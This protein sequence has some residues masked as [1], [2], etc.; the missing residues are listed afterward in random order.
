MK[1]GF[2]RCMVFSQAESTPLNSSL[3]GM[4]ALVDY[5]VDYRA[6]GQYQSYETDLLK[7]AFLLSLYDQNQV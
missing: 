4:R 6:Y 2:S 3:H 7:N 5:N 1:E